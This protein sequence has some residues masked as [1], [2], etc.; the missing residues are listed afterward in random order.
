MAESGD[1]IADYESYLELYPDGEHAAAVRERADDLKWER[2]RNSI[3]SARPEVSKMG[4]ESTRRGCMEQ[5]IGALEVRS[6]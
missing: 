1:S 3:V 6:A 2:I 4:R 5:A